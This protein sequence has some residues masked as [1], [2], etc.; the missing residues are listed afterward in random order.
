MSISLFVLVSGSA[1]ANRADEMP[2]PDL[3]FLACPQ[4][5]Y[6]LVRAQTFSIEEYVVGV[7]LRSSRR[8]PRWAKG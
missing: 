3:G 6:R 7:M 2:E 1:F 8:H 5:G 4:A